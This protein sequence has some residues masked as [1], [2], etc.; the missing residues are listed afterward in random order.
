VQI[1]GLQRI[2]RPRARRRMARTDAFDGDFHFSSPALRA[3]A[4]MPL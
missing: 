1:D 3:A 2:G 4:S